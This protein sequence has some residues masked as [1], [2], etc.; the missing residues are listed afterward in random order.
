MVNRDKIPLVTRVWES[1]PG[2]AD[3]MTRGPLRVREATSLREEILGHGPDP[4][5]RPE[6]T[7]AGV[8][9]Q[10]AALAIQR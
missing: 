9:M 5:P 2:F 4:H 7:V 10:A 8:Y 6:V 3:Q 1:A